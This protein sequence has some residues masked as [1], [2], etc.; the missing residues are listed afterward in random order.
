MMDRIAPYLDWMIDHRFAVVF[1][2]SVIDA[3]GLPFPGRIILVMAGTLA[4]V[5][6]D[7]AL[8]VVLATVGL[9]IGD[10]AL[11]LAGALGGPR[12]IAL[13]CRISLA[14][15][16][17]VENTMR[18][19]R[20]FGPAAVVLG[21]FSFGVR[22]FAA[23]LAGAGHL[24][25]RAFVGYDLV[26]TIVYSTL[27]IVLGHVFGAVVLERVRL[28]RVLLLIGPLAIAGV[29]LFRLIRRRRYGHAASR[30]VGRP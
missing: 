1:F 10:H 13:Y 30:G 7:L 19:F 5:P 17:C 23:I 8:M 9:V 29:L 25:Y 20:R 4:D 6:E 11:Y 14:S 28:A 2:A 22:L 12:L 15:E 16:R 18:Y 26:G 21:R 27:W 24:R 3:T